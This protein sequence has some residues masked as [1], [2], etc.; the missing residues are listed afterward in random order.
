MLFLFVLARHTYSSCPDKDY[1]VYLDTLSPGV[2]KAVL[3]RYGPNAEPFFEK[4]NPDTTTLS[5][6]RNTFRFVE[7]KTVTELQLRSLINLKSVS[8]KTIVLASLDSVTFSKLPNMDSLMTVHWNA[9]QMYKGSLPKNAFS[10]S[11]S[12]INMPYYKRHGMLSLK[13]K[14][15][16][17]FLQKGIDSLLS[18]AVAEQ[19]GP[20]LF[21]SSSFVVEQG[22]VSRTGFY[23]LGLPG[24]S[25]DF[26]AL[27]LGVVNVKS[28]R[29]SGEKL[30]IRSMEGGLYFYHTG[31]DWSGYRV[32]ITNTKGVVVHT[33]KMVPFT[34]HAWT[35]S[36]KM[37]GIYHVEFLAGANGN[38]KRSESKKVLL[39]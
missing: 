6:W 30:S 4:F 8:A 21:S 5:K 15:V 36:K 19:D 10:V 33:F 3:Y 11:A 16:V 22:R 28:P 32:T 17:L 7:E 1:G 2:V 29:I 37:T 31:L 24:V 18:Q 20:C 23:W 9:K 25:L 12:L 34:S 27:M 39:W 14:Q 13:G 26:S 35:P 38:H